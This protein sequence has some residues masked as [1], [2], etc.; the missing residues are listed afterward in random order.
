MSYQCFPEFRQEKFF[1]DSQYIRPMQR[2]VE[3]NFLGYMLDKVRDRANMGLR[4]YGTN[5]SATRKVKAVRGLVPEY[6]L[7]VVI[8]NDGF[9]MGFIAQK[10]SLPVLVTKMDRKIR[11]GSKSGWN[12]EGLWTDVN[13]NAIDEFSERT[14]RNKRVIVFEGDIVTGSTLKRAASEIAKYGP[15]EMDL[16]LHLGHNCISF[17]DYQRFKE[18]GILRSDLKD[19]TNKEDYRFGEIRLDT[20]PQVEGLFGKILSLDLDYRPENWGDHYPVLEEFE[21]MFV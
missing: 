3:N 18:K 2:V 4:F 9:D 10:Y 6:D 19:H 1:R 16:M 5:A 8:A 13:W 7:G 14:I 15:K 17:Q 11:S 12:S 21:A 20:R